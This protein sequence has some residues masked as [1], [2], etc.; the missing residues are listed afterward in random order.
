MDFHQH[1]RTTSTSTTNDDGSQDEKVREV[2][3]Y[4]RMYLHTNRDGGKKE[5]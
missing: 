1:R 3:S 4:V 2:T 5:K